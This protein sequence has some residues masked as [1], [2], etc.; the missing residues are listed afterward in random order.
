[1]KKV[2]LIFTPYNYFTRKIIILKVLAGHANSAP[3]FS[4]SFLSNPIFQYI[5]LLYDATS[6]NMVESKSS[7]QNTSV[8]SCPQ[9]AAF[10]ALATRITPSGFLPHTLTQGCYKPLD[11]IE[12][13]SPRTPITNF[14]VAEGQLFQPLYSTSLPV[15]G[16]WWYFPAIWSQISTLKPSLPH[17]PALSFL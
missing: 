14:V 6:K 11:D 4:S 3:F 17:F 15:H 1:M 12:R 5:I 7:T 16:G 13:A 2:K 9:Q 8:I 10:A